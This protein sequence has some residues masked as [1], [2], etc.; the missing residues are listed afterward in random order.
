M[1]KLSIITIN[2]NNVKGLE[3][4]INSVVNQSYND[5][6]YIIIDGGSTD[7][8]VD[9]IKKHENKIVFWVSEPDNGIY[10]A[11]NKGVKHSNGEYLLFLNGDDCLIDDAILQKISYHLEFK[12]LIYFDIYFDILS[13]IPIPLSLSKSILKIFIR[14]QMDRFLY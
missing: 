6:E 11:L 12:D 13:I 7:G 5:F 14:L 9:I 1:P 3:K 8:S 4:T 2:Y 10:D